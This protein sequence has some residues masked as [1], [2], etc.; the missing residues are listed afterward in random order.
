MTQG[1][2]KALPHSINADSAPFMNKLETIKP[3][4][5]EDGAS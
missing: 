4:L 2:T 3:V 1:L 5:T